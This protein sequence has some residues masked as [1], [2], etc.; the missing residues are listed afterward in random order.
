MKKITKKQRTIALI[1]V[2]LLFVGT[3]V[4]LSLPYINNWRQQYSYKLELLGDEGSEK[5]LVFYRKAEFIY[6]R[7]SLYLKIGELYDESGRLELA[8]RYFNKIK[9]EDITL[10]LVNHYLKAGNTDKAR[11]LLASVPH[12]DD[13]LYYHT[14]ILALD[15][16][17]KA[18]ETIPETTDQ[19]LMNFK[20]YLASIVGNTNTKYVDTA[21]A[22]YLYNNGYDNLALNKLESHKDSNYKDAHI[23][24]GDIYTSQNLYINAAT[25]YESAR[26]R[27]SYDINIYPKLISAYELLG[28]KDKADEYT[29]ALEKL[30]I[31]L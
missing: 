24:M 17:P 9:S 22:L 30:T 1:T 16:P 19:R 12:S 6:P 31:Q 11:S 26:I 13:Y 28:N 2:S 14:L 8:E 3:S 20:T 5:K 21:I 7:E 18:L 25:A 15:N 10:E 4:Y 23:L 29:V 27:D